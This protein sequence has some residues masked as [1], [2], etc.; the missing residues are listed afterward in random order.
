MPVDAEMLNERIKSGDIKAF[1]TLFNAYYTHLTLFANRFLNDLDASEEIVSDSFVVLWEKRSTLEFTSS[2]QSYLYKMVQ[3]KCLNYIKRRKI[4]N[5]YVSYLAKN[6]LLDDYPDTWN[7]YI[8]KDLESQARKAI[9]TLP[10][11][12]REIFKLSRFEHLKN[13]EIAQKL[14][15]S[16]KTVE[17]QITIAL[18]KLRHHFK[19]TLLSFFF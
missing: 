18:E 1:E 14:N 4:E 7:A 12:C 17:R 13:K 9:E 8:Q 11:K 16:E 10:E 19:N 6:N 5:E 15:L 3:N 2:V